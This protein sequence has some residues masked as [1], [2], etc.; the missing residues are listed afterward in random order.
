MGSGTQ[1]K[2]QLKHQVSEIEMAFAKTMADRDFAAFKSFLSEEAVF[3]SGPKPLR[4]KQEVAGWWQHYYDQPLA[5]FSWKPETVE[6]LNSGVLALSAGP[7]YDPNGKI[8]GT[9]TSIWRLEKD[10]KWRIVFDKGN[11]ICD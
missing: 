5:P 2:E 1:S 4:G 6:V 7:V 10:G 9:F 8:T 3:F 11:D